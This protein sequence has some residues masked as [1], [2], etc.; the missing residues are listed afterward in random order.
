MDNTRQH[1]TW[2][3][4]NIDAKPII[5]RVNNNIVMKIYIKIFMGGIISKINRKLIMD[6]LCKANIIIKEEIYK[7]NFF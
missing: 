1:I 3:Y 7:S 5:C 2:N 4:Y 6:R